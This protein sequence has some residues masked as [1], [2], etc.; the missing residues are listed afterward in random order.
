MS[1]T[2]LGAKKKMSGGGV[3]EDFDTSQ[4][5]T[6]E[7][8]AEEAAAGQAAIAAKP[9]NKTEWYEENWAIGIWV[10]LALSCIAFVRS[11]VIPPLWKAL[12]ELVKALGSLVKALGSLVRA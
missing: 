5:E 11:F 6:W 7:D 10:I 12:V 8:A 9:A 3:P 1:R 4:N 2:Q